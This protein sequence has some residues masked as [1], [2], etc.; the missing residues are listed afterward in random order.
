MGWIVATP[1]PPDIKI[2]CAIA[3]KRI[4]MAGYKRV[5][6]SVRQNSARRHYLVRMDL[7]A[8]LW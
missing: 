2:K 1:M 8:I 6:Q 5:P 4:A 3:R 7:K